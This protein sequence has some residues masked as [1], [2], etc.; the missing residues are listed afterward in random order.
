MSL[1]MDA[2]RKAEHS[3]QGSEAEVPSASEK[4]P[5]QSRP[6]P[7]KQALEVESEKRASDESSQQTDKLELTLEP[8]L[9]LDLESENTLAEES[10][11]AKQPTLEAL[12]SATAS[13]EKPSP[14][15]K[16]PELSHPRLYSPVVKRRTAQCLI[17]PIL[18][19]FVL[20][21]LAGGYFYFEAL[22]KS[23][24]SNLLILPSSIMMPAEGAADSDSAGM[25]VS[26]VKKSTSNQI[27]ATPAPQRQPVTPE[28]VTA[29]KRA[30]EESNVE[31]PKQ[32]LIV[33]PLPAERTTARAAA[34]KAPVQVNRTLQKNHLQ[35][36][37]E[38]AYAAYQRGDTESAKVLY[39]QAL[40]RAPKSRDALLGLAT[41]NQQQGSLQQAHHYYQQLLQMNPK[42]SH[43]IVGI[44]S[45]QG[46]A[47][48]SESQ[49][50]LLL[51]QE[52]NAAHLHFALGSQYVAQ[53]RW[54]EAQQAFFEAFHNDPQ[55]PDYIYNLAISLDHLTQRKMAL[56]YYRRALE[57]APGT[58]VGFDIGRLKQRIAQLTTRGVVK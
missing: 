27:P 41:V 31:V 22:L 25:M 9:S 56:V 32:P 57:Q 17:M 20:L 34:E 3:K 48:R 12:P 21:G 2:L 11:E 37:L 5:I 40:K 16:S 33:K 28:I 45:L 50:K 14:Q 35:L 1:L 44:L 39:L 29:K 30:L 13:P 43:A 52:P 6:E 23:D 24:Q 38:K 15:T 8:E 49:I 7:P 54:A 51:E 58:P 19:G 42:D 10:A 47:V 4:Q 18:L 26:E 36:Q 53:S 46:S 55:N